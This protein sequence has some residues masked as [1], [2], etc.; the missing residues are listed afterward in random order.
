MLNWGTE[1]ECAK[2][3]EVIQKHGKLAEVRYLGSLSGFPMSHV[4]FS[5]LSLKFNF[6]LI[7]PRKK[8]QYKKITLFVQRTKNFKFASPHQ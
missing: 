2:V 8:V 4:T 1:E 7:I 3:T 5:F 6:F